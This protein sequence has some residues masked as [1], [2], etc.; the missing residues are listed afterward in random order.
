MLSSTGQDGRSLEMAVASE[1]LVL[2][3]GPLD[4]SWI[5][6][7]YEASLCSSR[8]A[9]LPCHL[10]LSDNEPSVGLHMETT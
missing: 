8:Q 3:P 9:M 6:S 1:S 5:F 10:S 2:C 7:G 4:C